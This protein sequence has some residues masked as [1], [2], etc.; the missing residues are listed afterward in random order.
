M[1]HPSQSDET[2]FTNRIGARHC[3]VCGARLT[4]HEQ[5]RGNACKRP[6]CQNQQ[7]RQDLQLQHEREMALRSKTL[8]RLEQAQS[9]LGIEQSGELAVAVLPSNERRLGNLSEKRKRKF[10][11]RLLQIIGKA[12]ALRW[13]DAPAR[14]RCPQGFGAASANTTVDL[15]I[16]NNACATCRGDCCAQGEDHAFI[17]VETITEYMQKHPDQRPRDVLHA[18]LSRLGQKTFLA[19]CVYHGANGCELPV[20][21]RSHLCNDFQCKGLNSLL[22]Q[23]HDVPEPRAFVATSTGTEIIRSALIDHQQRIPYNESNT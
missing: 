18:Y 22:G 12:T 11:D 13:G 8:E 9:S 15:P 17:Q 21:M 14:D 3:A 23:V 4:V 16:L 5:V 6:G 10:R 20:E 2:E 7:L 1:L 19:S